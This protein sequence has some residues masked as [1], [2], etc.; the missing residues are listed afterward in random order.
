MDEKEES[1][2]AH[3]GQDGKSMVGKI[4]LAH[5]KDITTIQWMEKSQQTMVF[6]PGDWVWIPWRDEEYLIQDSRTNLFEEGENDTCSGGHLCY[7]GVKGQNKFVGRFDLLPICL[8][9]V[10]DKFFEGLA[11][12]PFR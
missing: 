8:V 6:E 1:Q 7:F 2:I 11:G 10:K 5:L 9:V 3:L 4:E 12:N